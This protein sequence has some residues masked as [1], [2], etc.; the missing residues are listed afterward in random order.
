MATIGL[1]GDLDLSAFNSN[2]R[3]YLRGVDQM[4]GET[5]KA[6]RSTSS[7]M[8]QASKDTDRFSFSWERIRDIVTAL[9]IRDAA[10][11]ITRALREIADE[12]FEAVG[13]FQRLRIQFESLA[14]RDLARQFGIPVSEALGKVSGAAQELL[15]WIRK[16]A[17]TTP[18]SVETISQTIAWGQ[19]F[20]FTVEQ[21]K[22][23]AVATGNFVA[24]MGLTNEQ[25]ERI[26]Y[27][28]GQ[29]L[30][31]GRILGRELRDLANNFVPIRDVIQAMADEAG[32]SFS[33]MRENM[34]KGIVPASDFIRTFIELADRDFPNAMER[35]SET[36]GG[37][38][39]NFQDFIHTILGL[40]VL[41]PLMDNLS[42]KA[43]DFIKTLFDQRVINTFRVIGLTLR[44]SVLLIFEA[45]SGE[46]VPALGNLGKSFGFS[47]PY[48]INLA[49]TMLKVAT[50][51]KFLISGL[52]RAINVLAEFSNTLTKKFGGTLQDL[53]RSAFS[54]G[55]NIVISLAKGIAS[56]I[57]YVIQAIASLASAIANLLAA[58]SAPKILPDLKAWG[59]AAAQE[60][61]SGW[62]SLNF[63]VF[64]DIASTVESFIRSLASKFKETDIVPRILGSRAAIAEIL[65]EVRNTGSVS[66]ASLN[67][68][69]R[70]AGGASDEL[71]ALV[72]S[73]FEYLAIAEEVDNINKI[74]DF[75]VELGAPKKIFGEVVSTLTDLVRVSLRVKGTLGDA[76][77]SYVGQL[78]A[79][80]EA[81]AKVARTQDEI[82]AKTKEY[83]ETLAS[84]REELE[85]V[86][87]FEDESSRLKEIDQAVSTG[88][89]TEE[90]KRRLELE[91]RRIAIERQIRTV[92]DERDTVI[93]SLNARL[94]AE[95]KVQELVEAG[96][97]RQQVIVQDL[98][99][100]QVAAAKEI[101]DANEALVGLLTDQN[102]LILEQIKLLESLK[103]AAKAEADAGDEEGEPEV[104]P[105]ELEF[106]GIFEGIEKNLAASLASL[107]A[108]LLSIQETVRLKI[109]AFIDEILQPLKDAATPISEAIQTI[110]D[111]FMEIVESP[112]I[113]SIVDAVKGFGE[114]LGI[115]F[116]NVRTFLETDGPTIVSTITGIFTGI[117]EAIGG[118]EEISA[119]ITGS[120][121]FLGDK[122][123]ELSEK[124]LEKGPEIITSLESFGTFITEEFIPKVQE[125]WKW[126]KDEA[127][128]TLQP[129]I[130]AVV[131]NFPLIVAIIGTLVGA[132]QLFSNIL[133]A[134]GSLFGF[135]GAILA[136]SA[137][138]SS[139]GVILPVVV[140]ILLAVVAGIAAV[141]IAI[142]TAAVLVYAF[143]TNFAGFRTTILGVWKA[144]TTTLQPA[145]DEL[146][147]A[148]SELAEVL[149]ISGGDFEDFGGTI[150]G[151]TTVVLEFFVRG[152]GLLAKIVG[153]FISGFIT[154]ITTFVTIFIRAFT[155]LIGTARNIIGGLKLIFEGFGQFFTSI[156]SGT[157]ED[158]AAGFGKIIQGILKVAQNFF[159]AVITSA[160]AWAGGLLSLMSGMITGIIGFFENLYE[161]LIGGSI[162]PEMWEDI[163]AS[164]TEFISNVTT[165]ISKFISDIITRLITFVNEV[166]TKVKKFLADVL[167]LIKAKLTDFYNAGVGLITKFKEGFYSLMETIKTGMKTFMNEVIQKIKDRYEDF[168]TSGK[169][170]MEKLKEGI[171]SLLNDI[172][173][174]VSNIIEESF[175]KIAE[176]YDDFKEAGKKL[177]GKIIEGLTAAKD[178]LLTWLTDLITELIESL[179]GGDGDGG[180][181][182]EIEAPPPASLSDSLV[183]SAAEERGLSDKYRALG[184]SLMQSLEAGFIVTALQVKTNMLNTLSELANIALQSDSLRSL[185]GQFAFSR[186]IGAGGGNLTYQNITNVE[187]N[188]TYRNMQ[189]EAS[190]YY[191]VSAA[192]T[193]AMR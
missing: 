31:S 137:A 47:I 158:V 126:F 174:T 109:Q 99:D 123:V 110:S 53:V 105:G 12:A 140:P 128:P 64:N 121:G 25:L 172:K 23:L 75:D 175:D 55:A 86:T 80:D 145:F 30:A 91:K 100:A 10:R 103:N 181:G 44:N 19:A 119:A 193:F 187:V 135:V 15:A 37:V 112:F 136:M 147:N 173:N 79:L 102:N 5:I 94:E 146:K 76:V 166:I 165:A 152:F 101:F 96:L 164:V 14:A 127:L 106:G 60:W 183:P 92:E 49:S 2:V 65:D 82:N 134:G 138:F 149:G 38:T 57:S 13:N 131:K 133:P 8:Q 190:I 29:M 35:M 176:W 124:L 185:S 97:K 69:V 74:L 54:W 122:I 98:A 90:E 142:G 89:L 61:L 159:K 113:T 169:T 22:R 9:F 41:G 59:L 21:A 84:L 115:A 68:L 36:I 43:N 179:L 168:K 1:L 108:A 62:T 141:G 4:V 33:Q 87:T 3:T 40:E 73:Y 24:G 88:L 125:G 186:Q 117:L 52:A 46:L 182:A 154:A 160:S 34:K 95:K 143:K 71:K 177:I 188:P 151:V 18:F 192:L 72:R 155:S 191:D 153:G 114:D 150:K 70:A 189:S 162:I 170:L 6:S 58:H 39:Q 50:A 66:E 67:K 156:F 107:E 7:A 17:V 42:K 81:T 78:I 77:R 167:A 184:S 26:I 63:D 48:A 148:L 111:S 139:L 51:I 132:I 171:K 163:I 93:D 28:F 27:N 157:F 161:E 20:G 130:D 16:I 32:V 144:L 83:E 11:T 104:E 178:K 56:A 45:I 180:G 85:A 116:G 120:I 129:F 118:P